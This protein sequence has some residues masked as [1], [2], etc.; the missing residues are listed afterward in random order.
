[1]GNN[2]FAISTMTDLNVND[3]HTFESTGNQNLDV[4]RILFEYL[5]TTEDSLK[6]QNKY[7]FLFL[8]SYIQQN[9]TE[10]L[11]R[12]LSDNALSDL[13]PSLLKSI[14]IMTEHLEDVNNNRE[15]VSQILN[16]KI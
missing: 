7:L 13:H 12:L 6:E 10:I 2:S 16:A 8:Q 15:S 11:N 3:L 9:N 5:F 4:I 1:M 14:L